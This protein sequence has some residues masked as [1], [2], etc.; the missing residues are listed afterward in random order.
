MSKADTVL[1]GVAGEY[2]VAAEL[3]RRGYIASLTSK[4]TKGID[5]LVSNQKGDKSASIQIKTNST[6]LRNWILNKKS[7]D[8]YNDKMFYVFVALKENDNPMYFVVKSGTVADYIKEKHNSWLM[9]PGRNGHHRNDTNMRKFDLFDDTY[10]DAW[11][12]LSLD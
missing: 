4:N 10:R 1:I 8:E 2:Y 7:E 11:H 12:M 5:M 6:G 9:T 3:S